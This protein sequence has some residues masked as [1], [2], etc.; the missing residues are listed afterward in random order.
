V[1]SIST[2]L[3]WSVRLLLMSD[4]LHII[5]GRN[6][7][8]IRIRKGATL[9]AVARAMRSYGVSS[10]TGRVADIELGRGAP[11]LTTLLVLSAALTDVTGQPVT[12]AELL[13]GDGDIAASN[14]V[15]ASLS[16]LRRFMCGGPA[17][18]NK[19]HSDEM[20]DADYRAAKSLGLQPEQA[21]LVMKQLWGH[22]LSKECAK[23]A[24]DGNPQARGIVTRELKAQLA[25]A[26]S[27]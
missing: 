10:S 6:A 25:A 19:A 18:L 13:A 5:I 2:S 4:R 15:S 20:S 8:A 24:P 11:T 16:D 21:A 3:R 23:R 22:T 14:T 26:A 27:T 12:A 7:R 9:D 17:R 1:G